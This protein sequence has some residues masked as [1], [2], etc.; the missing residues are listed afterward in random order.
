M[1][2]NFDLENMEE[3]SKFFKRNSFG[4]SARWGDEGSDQSIAWRDGRW[5]QS[6]TCL[7]QFRGCPVS[8]CFP[9]KILAQTSNPY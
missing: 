3:E 6:T 1:K 2:S 5:A 7:K 9:H 4:S 8:I